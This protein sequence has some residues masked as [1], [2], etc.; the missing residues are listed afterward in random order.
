MSAKVKP[1]S[2]EDLGRSMDDPP[3]ASAPRFKPGQ[4]V[5]ANSTTGCHPFTG[6][7]D[8]IFADFAAA[9]LSGGGAIGADWWG[10]QRVTPP[11]KRQVFYSVVGLGGRGAV[12]VGERG[13]G[14]A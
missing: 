8:A 5:K 6:Y 10:L 7:V 12:I 2:V 13:L 9:R 4:K 3:L 11:T 14:P 1:Y